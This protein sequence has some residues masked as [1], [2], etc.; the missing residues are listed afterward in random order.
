MIVLWKEI[1]C[2]FWENA[3]IESSEMSERDCLE[4]FCGQPASES[5]GNIDVDYS[6]RYRVIIITLGSPLQL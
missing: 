6:R 4:L 2:F 5:K 1:Y 3:A